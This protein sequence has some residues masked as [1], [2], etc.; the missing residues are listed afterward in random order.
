MTK[1]ELLNFA[2]FIFRSGEESFKQNKNITLDAE[3]QKYI[4]DAFKDYRDS[5]KNKTNFIEPIKLEDAQ[6]A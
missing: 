5:L 4:L 3:I 6:D 1:T 2:K